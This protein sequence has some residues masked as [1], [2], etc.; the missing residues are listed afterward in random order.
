[1]DRLAIVVVTYKRQHLLE[2]LLRSLLLLDEAP[3][4]VFVVD[5]EDASETREL[6]EIY[7]RIVDEGLTA[8]PW[9]SGKDTLVYVPM[10]TNTGGAGGFSEGV[11]RAY[12]AGAQ[13]FWLMDDDVAVMPDAIAKLGRWAADFDI[14][15]GARLDWD[16]GRFFWQHH[17]IESMG[18]YD[19]LS[20]SK[21]TK[22]GYRPMNAVC[23]EGGLFNRAIAERIGPPDAR[24][25][26]YWDDCVY[27]YCASKHGRA[28]VV[29]DV[30]LQR[31]REVPNWEVTGVRQLNASSDMTRYH[32]MRNRGH[33]AHYLKEYGDY[34]PVLFGAGTL[35]CLAKE[36][37]RLVVVERQGVTAGARTLVRG[38]RDARAIMADETWRPMGPAD[39]ADDVAVDASRA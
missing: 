39:L 1:M 6:I 34:N 15:Q 27:G 31:T 18:M 24:F 9:T 25:F 21:P 8:A 11:R 26:I 12:Q 20:A 16:G 29:D 30:V 5:N 28:A 35:A 4:R 22:A 37:I 38:W 19:P 10:E 23:F 17:F 2:G 33:M 14:V 13:W 36:L 3:W 32:V 7:A